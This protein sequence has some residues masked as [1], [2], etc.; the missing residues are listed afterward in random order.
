MPWATLQSEQHPVL[1]TG[2][3]RRGVLADVLDA[4]RRTAEWLE[5]PK[6]A[7]A[8]EMVVKRARQAGA[9]RVSGGSPSAFCVIGVALALDAEL[10]LY[11]EGEPAVVLLIDVAVAS[12]IGM[13]TIAQR[14]IMTGAESVATMVIDAEAGQSRH[15]SQ[16]SVV[17]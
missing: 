14:L 9:Q 5:S 12:P 7:L 17:A 1:P 6:L 15:S 13:N 8:A 2:A 11:E 16:L 4:R 10:R 3:A